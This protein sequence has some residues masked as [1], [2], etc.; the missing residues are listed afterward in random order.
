MSG[1]E[2]LNVG[3]RLIDDERQRHCLTVF[4]PG[5]RRRA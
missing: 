2:K 4:A 5:G 1:T 3:I